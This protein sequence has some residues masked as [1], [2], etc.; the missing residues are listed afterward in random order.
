MR[1]AGLALGLLLV[2]STGGRAA[3]VEVTVGGMRLD[4][5]TGTP[6]VQLVEKADR[7]RE[8]PIWIGPFE[9]QAI[10]LELQGVPPPRPLTHDL[11]KQLVERLGAKLNRVVIEDLRDSTYIATVHLDGPG[12]GGVKVDARPSDAIAL[13]LR[14]RGPILV[15]E[16]LFAKAATTRPPIPTAAHIWG[17]TLQDL[18]PEMAR[19]FEAPGARGVLVSDVADAAS[20]HEALRGDVI[21]AVDGAPVASVD[22]LAKRVDARAAAD[23]VRLSVRRHG[24]D[25]TITFASE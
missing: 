24:R 20:A 15:S 3:P 19:F 22:D 7:G 18:T 17:L 10:A 2:C 14:L 4:V 6:V 25:V 13:A 8:L 23:P 11:M 1:R 16:E 21:T 9:A 5:S 12:G